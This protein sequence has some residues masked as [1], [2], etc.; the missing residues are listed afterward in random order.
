MGGRPPHPVVSQMGAAPVKQPRPAVR[1]MCPPVAGG[2]TAPGAT[3]A[4]LGQGRDHDRA[5]STAGHTKD[6]GM[7]QRFMGGTW[8]ARCGT[9]RGNG[10]LHR[11]PASWRATES[12][13]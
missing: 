12:D 3:L 2:C 6:L 1:Q 10:E 13:D 8:L 11:C 5:E 7:A 9:S 4:L